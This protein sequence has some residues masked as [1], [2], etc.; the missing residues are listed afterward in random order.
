MK[1]PALSLVICSHHCYRAGQ[2]KEKQH[3]KKEKK[4]KVGLSGA[5]AL[6]EAANKQSQCKATE[7]V[8]MG[9]VSKA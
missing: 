4:M 6:W 7:V 3:L 5:G 2:W 9:Q 8:R 1:S